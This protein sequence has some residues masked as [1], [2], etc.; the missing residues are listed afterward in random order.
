MMGF[1][2]E[3]SGK[4]LVDGEILLESPLIIGSGEKKEEVD[5][6]VIKDGSG[7]PYIPATSLAGALRHYFYQ[8]ADLSDVKD[9][10]QLRYF[11][12]ED[13]RDFKDK[14]SEVYQSALFISDAAACDEAFIRIRDGV[15]LADCGIAKDEKKFEYEIVE[16]G[17][18][19]KLK[20]EVNLRKKYEKELEL[21][22]KILFFLL[23]SLQG[24][25]IAIGAMTT[26]GFGRCRL[27]NVKV[28]QLN[29]SNPTDVIAWL[30]RGYTPDHEVSIN[31]VAIFPRR[32]NNFTIDALMEIKNS[33]IIRS[34]SGDP[35]DPD[36][37]HITSRGNP[38]LPGTSV[39]G[40]I[41]QR[42]KRIINTLGG[43]GEGLVKGLFGNVDEETKEKIKSRLIVEETVVEN[44]I[45]EVQHRIKIDRF[46]GG[47]MK[48][49]LFNTMPLWP[50]GNTGK[51]MVRIK[52]SI[53]GGQ[54][55]Y[56]DWEA[57]LLLLILKDLWNE[58]LAIGG[59]KSIGRGVLRGIRAEI[60]F[61]DKR[62]AEEK[63][64]IITRKDGDKINKKDENKVDITG[65]RELLEGFVEALVNKCKGKEV[66]NE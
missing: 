18:R 3:L 32:E 16:P 36:A 30:C 29:F 14:K 62:T 53:D 28:Y 6:P 2:A 47:A 54:E 5:I 23:K 65:E 38:V 49:A 42:A 41:R 39:K 31:N 46:T 17:I 40:A 59:E 51:E 10:Q 57:G 26:K 8:N 60:S 15:A 9:L 13:Y 63:R 43:D 66:N 11:W 12:G 58:D 4:L 19:F 20:M 37:V 1:D 34:Y 64:I 22:K 56:K 44:T 25:R 33:L 21:F 48:T 45:S 50:D 27:N 55:G 24:G 7:R 35:D 61:R 52:L